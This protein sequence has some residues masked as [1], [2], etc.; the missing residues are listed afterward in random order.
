MRA[1]T[2]QRTPET[3]KE[4]VVAYLNPRIA[5]RLKYE[6]AATDKSLSLIIEEALGRQF[7]NLTSVVVAR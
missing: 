1:T 3:S 4:R 7:E 2:K 5:R 6:K